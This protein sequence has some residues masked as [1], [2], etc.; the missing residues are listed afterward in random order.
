VEALGVV[1]EGEEV[2]AVEGVGVVEV[3]EG[4][5]PRALASCSTPPLETQQSYTLHNH[6]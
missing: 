1:G 2:V 6:S 4:W 5:V 3:E